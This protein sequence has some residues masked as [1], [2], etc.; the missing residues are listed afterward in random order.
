[1]M[2]L[3]WHSSRLFGTVCAKGAAAASRTAARRRSLTRGSGKRR[4]GSCSPSPSPSFSMAAL[5]K[6]PSGLRRNGPSTIACLWR[7]SCLAENRTY[8][9]SIA[10][11]LKA[12]SALSVFL[13][14]ITIHLGVGVSLFGAMRPLPQVE[15]GC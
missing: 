14:I 12:F 13:H 10:M 3:R 5:L 9:L 4:A 11:G 6:C 7:R 15:S 2:T 8:A 1:M